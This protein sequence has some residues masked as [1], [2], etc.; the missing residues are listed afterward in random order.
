MPGRGEETE[1]EENYVEVEDSD[2]EEERDE[3]RLREMHKESSAY[4]DVQAR[5]A[6]VYRC[7][8][9]TAV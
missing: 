4:G 7:L 1:G 3:E 6:R 8:T 9:R 2:E 5:P